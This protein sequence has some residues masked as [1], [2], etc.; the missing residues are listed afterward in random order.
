MGGGSGVLSVLSICYAVGTALPCTNAGFVLHGRAWGSAW[1]LLL[2][3]YRFGSPLSS[4]LR[5]DI[6]HIPGF[7]EAPSPRRSV[8][9]PDFM[10]GQENE[11]KGEKGEFTF[12]FLACFGSF[13][14]SSLARMR[15]F[16]SAFLM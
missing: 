16:L 11:N 6:S 4:F 7:P 1:N 14:A 10:Q 12:Y 3:R 5:F 9:G 15:K 8:T 13:F 2:F